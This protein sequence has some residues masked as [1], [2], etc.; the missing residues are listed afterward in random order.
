M[1]FDI[2]KHNK[3]Y[4]LGDIILEQ[5]HRY[6]HDREIVLT[7]PKYKD[8]FLYKY[9]TNIG[10]I[11]LVDIFNTY[12][13]TITP[14][15]QT[16]YIN[17]RLGDVVMKNT[18]EIH[19][20]ECYGKSKG[21]FLYN[22]EKLYNMVTTTIDLNKQINNICLVSALH[23]GDN[24]MYNIWKWSSE[25]EHE[26]YKLLEPILCKLKEITK[27]TITYCESLESD[28]KTID[29]HFLTLCLAE[30]VIVDNSFF[31]TVVNKMRQDIPH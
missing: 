20:P 28:I 30:H 22:P 26:N 25:A 2:Y 7:N 13:D 16:L 21:T 9:L 19:H 18:G 8:S 17:L 29:Y 31:G 3:H 27:H 24:E 23:F 4:R 10:H 5:G 15:N 6:K 14:S 12:S 1:K 11:P